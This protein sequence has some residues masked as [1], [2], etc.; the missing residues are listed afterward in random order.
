MTKPMGLFFTVIFS[1][2][3]ICAA[4]QPPIKTKTPDSIR[5][6]FWVVDGV[7]VETDSVSKRNLDP[8]NIESIQVWKGDSAVIRFGEKGR[9][10]VIVVTT[11]KA[12]R[13]NK[14]QK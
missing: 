14:K 13:Q 3:M 8:E 11:K 6:A 7:R 10:G 1:C 5:P 12:G 9:A 2:L 4:A